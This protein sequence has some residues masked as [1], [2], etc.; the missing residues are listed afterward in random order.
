VFLVFPSQTL[1]DFASLFSEQPN[2]I[3]RMTLRFTFLFLVVLATGV[4]PTQADETYALRSQVP[5]D[6]PALPI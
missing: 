1:R 3:L 6:C 5:V 4:S 2:T